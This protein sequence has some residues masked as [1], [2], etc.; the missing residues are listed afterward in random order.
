MKASL[1]QQP[2]YCS[3]DHN[4]TSIQPTVWEIYTIS[5][6]FVMPHCDCTQE[7]HF[8]AVISVVDQNTRSVSVSKICKI[9]SGCGWP[10]PMHNSIKSS[11]WKESWENGVPSP[12]GTA[13]MQMQCAKFG[14]HLEWDHVLLRQLLWMSWTSWGGEGMGKS[15]YLG[16]R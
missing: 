8:A 4:F 6:R 16:W 7:M 12:W 13:K 2:M 5:D 11:F 1:Q 15:M 3:R 14:A 10:K 9:P